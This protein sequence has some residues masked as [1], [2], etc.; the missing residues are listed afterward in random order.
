MRTFVE[1]VDSSE[2]D[3]DSVVEVPYVKPLPP[4]IQLSGSEA[5]EEEVSGSGGTGNVPHS[6]HRSSGGKEAES[7][8]KTASSSAP[9][10]S[11]RRERD[12]PAAAAAGKRSK[13]R[14]G[15][16]PPSRDAEPGGGS[17]DETGGGCRSGPE[18]AASEPPQPVPLIHIS[19]NI[20]DPS[21]N[22]LFESSGGGEGAGAAPTP[23]PASAGG[24]GGRK[25]TTSSSKSVSNSSFVNFLKSINLPVPDEYLLENET[26]AGKRKRA[27]TGRKRKAGMSILSLSLPQNHNP[28]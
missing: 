27:P 10:K 16:Q 24:G 9:K 22:A 20:F 14:P 26:A 13:S 25:R 17:C 21:H 5:E 4:T 7:R 2:D 12:S 23:S 6:S 11:K 19:T 18:S 3:A 8:G 1:A 15:P 28:F